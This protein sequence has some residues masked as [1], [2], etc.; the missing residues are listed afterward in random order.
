[1][2]ET[3]LQLFAQ[4][5]LPLGNEDPRHVNKSSAVMD[6]CKLSLYTSVWKLPVEIADPCGPR[7]GQCMAIISTTELAWK[8]AKP[9]LVR[10]VVAETITMS[11]C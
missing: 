7:Q 6:P 10:P 1:M 8:R 11:T 9:V 2:D 3:S 4:L 5:L